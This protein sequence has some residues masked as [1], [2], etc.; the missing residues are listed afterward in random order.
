MFRDNIL[1]DQ[2]ELALGVI[3]M[4]RPSASQPKIDQ[5]IGK[6]NAV[7][8]VAKTCKGSDGAGT[9]RDCM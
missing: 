9:E 4:S 2:D 7:A 5:T 3:V 6:S 8:L 1:Q